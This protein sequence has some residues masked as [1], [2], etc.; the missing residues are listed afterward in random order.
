MTNYFKGADVD[1]QQIFAAAT[2]ST[3]DYRVADYFAIGSTVRSVINGQTRETYYVDSARRQTEFVQNALSTAVSEDGSILDTIY[4]VAGVDRLA[5]PAH[6]G[7]R[8]GSIGAMNYAFYPEQIDGA[9]AL[10]TAAW[11]TGPLHEG[12]PESAGDRTDIVVRQLTG[13]SEGFVEIR[14][15]DELLQ[16]V[17]A[18]AREYAFRTDVAQTNA[19]QEI[20]WV[21]QAAGF[22]HTAMDSASA[23][24]PQGSEIVAQA[25]A[26]YRDMLRERMQRP[27]NEV[28]VAR[29][30]QIEAHRQ[31]TQ[32]NFRNFAQ[33]QPVEEVLV[34]T[35]PFVPNGLASSRRWGIE[36]ESGGARGVETPEDWRSVS[37][38]SLRSAYDGYVEVQDFEPF[39][40]EVTEQV[41]WRECA[42]ADRHLPYI[43]EFSEEQG[44]HI[45]RT[46]EDFIPVDECQ[47]CG[48]VTHMVR[49][50]PQTIRHSARSG[51]CREF[52]SP[53]LT[54]M[55]SRG[56]KQLT[57]ALSKNPQNSSAGV[58]V[59]VEADDLSPKQ[60]QTLVFGYDILEPLLESSYK[61][62]RRDFCRRREVDAVLSHARDARSGRQ[63]QVDDRYLT[64]NLQSLNRHG[65]IEFRAMGPVYEYDHL[66]RWAMLCRELVN[67]VAAGATMK[68]FS[69]VTNW[70]SLLNLLARFGKEY[71][72]AAVYEMTGEVGE[73]AKL[74]KQG[75]P[76]TQDALASDL[77]TA[78]ETITAQFR[79]FGQSVS[80]VG[81]RLVGVGSTNET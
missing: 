46:R 33:R 59:H 81:A 2:A 60:I 37:D 16:R 63:L 22:I 54:S 71:I 15:S 31:Q 10:S 62:E 27:N 74:E 56:L 4:M 49:R 30:A 72:R 57:E 52:V 80:E 29:Q 64:L 7:R 25:M 47:A 43:E 24:Y 23:T 14:P 28:E 51:D 36:V 6:Q 73:A 3:L 35:L 75:V 58:H 13:W 61:R 76:V 11:F 42:N 5:F 44:E 39:D 21:R 9:V 32:Q 66:I 38:G 67:A 68:D 77:S 53:I 17:P 40:E 69:K 70:S 48:N 19:A 20:F 79:A 50:E 26:T 41:T 12:T 78:W 1:W 65:T 45:F 18:R 8:K 34:P 55:H